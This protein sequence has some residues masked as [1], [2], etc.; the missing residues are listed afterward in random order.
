[1]IDPTLRRRA[2]INARIHRF[3]LALA[4]EHLRLEASSTGRCE[5]VRAGRSCGEHAP[6]GLSWLTRKPALK[7]A[8]SGLNGGEWKCGRGSTASLPRQI[9]GA[10]DTV[11]TCD[12]CLLWA[13]E[14]R[15]CP[16]P[17]NTLSRRPAAPVAQLDR[18]L[19]S[20]GII[21][22]FRVDRKS[23]FRQDTPPPLNLYS[24]QQAQ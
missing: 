24:S 16:A 23:L 18:A 7:K 10:S 1:M 2:V 14:R 3:K 19:P 4:P 8:A 13:L 21:I 22:L 5:T 6:S 12:R 11:R 15:R 20:E 9:L 17:A